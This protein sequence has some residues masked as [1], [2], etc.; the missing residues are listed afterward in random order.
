MTHTKKHRKSSGSMIMYFSV[1]APTASNPT[2]NPSVPGPRVLTFA[3]TVSSEAKISWGDGSHDLYTSGPHAATHTYSTSGCYKVKI[4]GKV[5]AFAI[6][7]GN[8]YLTGIE[9]FGKLGLNDLTLGFNNCANL[10]SV[11]KHLPSSV[12]ILSST[13]NTCINLNGKNLEKWD[14]SH[15]ENMSNMFSSCTNFNSDLSKWNVK[16]LSNASE[17]FRS[18]TN[19]HSDLSKWNVKNLSDASRM[20]QG[21]TNFNS[22]LSKWNV[23]NL[24][25]ASGMFR[26]CTNFNSDL[27]KWNVENL[28][29]ASGMFGGCFNFSSDLSKW[30]VEKL[31]NASEMFYS[32]INFN[33]DLSKWKINNVTTMMLMLADTNISIKNYNKLLRA[34]SQLAFITTTGIKLGAQNLVFSSKYQS[35]RTALETK[36]AGSGTAYP[37]ILGDLMGK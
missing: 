27:S 28:S 13:F 35:T 25:D 19:F 30:N 5:S 2:T 26:A 24:S 4:S 7:V 6:S 31:N 20:F 18:C 21:C 23:K 12:T 15:V 11:P 1:D 33:S 9:S 10:V 3:I 16:N 22:D 37:Y 8:I 34:W 29:N 32:C 17:M 36:L 14:V